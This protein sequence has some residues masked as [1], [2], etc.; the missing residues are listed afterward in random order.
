MMGLSEILFFS[1]AVPLFNRDSHGEEFALHLSAA[2]RSWCDSGSKK[3][4]EMRLEEDLG[5]SCNLYSSNRRL[6]KL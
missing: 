3:L 4:I 1:L 5:R 2:H 6:A